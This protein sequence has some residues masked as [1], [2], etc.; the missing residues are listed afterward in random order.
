MGYRDAMIENG[1]EFFFTN[2]HCH[3]G[4]YPLYQNQNAFRLESN[5]KLYNM[6]PFDLQPRIFFKPRRKQKILAENRSDK[7]V[8]NITSRNNSLHPS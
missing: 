4:M 7:A 5:P 8:H 2:V 3:H 1:V 6:Y